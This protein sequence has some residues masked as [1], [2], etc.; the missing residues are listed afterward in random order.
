MTTQ[1]AIRPSKLKE[2]SEPDPKKIYDKELHQRF[3]LWK[4]KTGTSLRKLSPMLRRSYTSISNYLNYRYEGDLQDLEKDIRA[5]LRRNEDLST[6]RDEFCRIST[7]RA[8]WQVLKFCHEKGKM[9]AVIG[10]SGVSKTLTASKYQE[11][12]RNAVIITANPTRMSLH[13]IIKEISYKVGSVTGRSSNEIFDG[14]NEKLR[15]S[16]KLLIIDEAHF[17]DWQSFEAIRGIYDA[18]GVGVVYLGMP[19]LYSQM[20][21]NKSY[22]WDQIL[23]RISISRSV[24]KIEKED[25]KLISDSIHPGLPKS[26]L[27]YLHEVAQRPGK[28]RVLVELLKQAVEVSKKEKIPITLN[29][30]KE[31]RQLMNIWEVSP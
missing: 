25:V 2:I 10:P 6:R 15:N 4:D 9:G 18:I 5:V 1:L 14:I 7:S 21:G 30:L 20:R 29:L 26:C 8:I 31:V 19:K 28:L 24:G 27:N 16:E 23:S 12:N 13:K 11:E 3:E 17:L 22:L